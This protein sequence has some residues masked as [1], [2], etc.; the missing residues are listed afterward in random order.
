MVTVDVATGLALFRLHKNNRAGINRKPEMASVCL[1]CGSIH[2]D[3]DPEN[4]RRLICR[5][6]GFAFYRYTCPACASTVD[7]RDPTN[8]SCSVCRIPKCTCGDCAC[9]PG[10]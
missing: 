7:S 1:I 4:P 8:P 9:S 2:V 3:P 10:R 6:C 5:N